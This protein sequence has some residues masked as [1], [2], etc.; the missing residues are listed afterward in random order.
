MGLQAQG[1]GKGRLQAQGAGRKVAGKIYRRGE[2]LEKA[3]I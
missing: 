3:T 2:E 1:V